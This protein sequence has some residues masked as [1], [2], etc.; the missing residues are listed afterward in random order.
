MR[1]RP[2]TGFGTTAAIAAALTTVTAALTVSPSVAAA[3][4]AHHE[5]P[6]VR[7]AVHGDAAVR[8]LS[9][10][11]GRVAAQN[12]MTSGELRG[13]LESDDSLW[14]APDRSLV[15][16]DDLGL[17]SDRPGQ[18][19]DE[20]EPVPSAR[21]LSTG[22]VLALHS[23][24]GADKVI[25][26]DV[27]GAPNIEQSWT[28]AGVPANLR[29]FDPADDGA[30][31]SDSERDQIE[32][33]WKLV[34]DRFASWNV[35]VTTEDPGPDGLTRTDEADTTY[36][37]QLIVT[38][39]GDPD[40]GAMLSVNG[41]ATGGFGVIGQP[42]RGYVFARSYF[43][44]RDVA[45]VGA[46]EVGHTLGLAHHTSTIHDD[47]YTG[48]ME[49]FGT[50]VNNWSPIMGGIGTPLVQ[51]SRGDF[52]GSNHAQD[53]LA[54]IGQHLALRA[55]EAPSTPGDAVALPAS[56]GYIT[57]SSDVD[58]YVLGTC[59]ADATVDVTPVVE[60]SSLDIDAALVH[61][62]NATPLTTSNE[63]S[64]YHWELAPPLYTT[65]V[66]SFL[67]M[68][69]SLKADAGSDYVL[70][71]RGGGNG[72]WADNG[73]DA[74][75]AV[76]GYTVDVDGCDGAA[77]G[78]SPGATAPGAPTAFAAPRGGE[79]LS[80]TWA[81]PW[82]DGGSAITG[83]RLYRL[84]RQDF[85]PATQAPTG[86]RT[87]VGSLIPA[88]QLSTS[89][90]AP[91][92]GTY[93]YQLVAVNTVGESASA[94]SDPFAYG[95]AVQ[96]GRA[97]AMQ[98]SSNREGQTVSV[99]A[100]VLSPSTAGVTYQ[101]KRSTPGGG[102]EA[103]AGATGNTYALAA[104]DIGR[105]ISV[106]ATATA[107]G[108]RPAQS[109][110]LASV[111]VVS[112]A[113]AGSGDF[114]GPTTGS[115]ANTTVPDNTIGTGPTALAVDDAGN[116]Y[117]PANGRTDGRWGNNYLRKFSAAG[118][119]VETWPTAPP[120]RL[121]V[122]INAVDVGPDGDVYAYD[123]ANR[124][125]LVYDPE[126]ALLRTWP[127]PT[128]G[129]M[130]LQD[131]VYGITVD[132]DGN[133]YVS[134]G[135][136]QAIQKFDA[137]GTRLAKWDS[138]GV[139]IR[140]LQA[141]SG[142]GGTI[143]Y[144]VDTTGQ[145]VKALSAA[146]GAPVGSWNGA[147]SGG[148]QF[149]YPTDVATDESGALYVL[150]GFNGR[151]QRFD[152][153]F[154]F[155]DEVTFS[156]VALGIDVGARG[157]VYVADNSDDEVERV[158][159]TPVDP[160]A[161]PEVT[162]SGQALSSSTPHVGVPVTAVKGTWSPSGAIVTYQW[163]V[164]SNVVSTSATYT[165][166]AADVGKPLTLIFTGTNPGYTTRTVTLTSS[167]V[168]RGTLTRPT[169]IALSGTYAV[170]KKLKVVTTGAWKPA[171]NLAYRWF[172][173]GKAITGATKSKLKLTQAQAGKKILVRITATA[174]G[175]NDVVIALKGKKVG[176]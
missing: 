59:T 90:P 113:S 167:P 67:G 149:S 74:Y 144:Y 137:D 106:T 9:R 112:A 81:K 25:F 2:A 100:P 21:T 103:I 119:L 43:R 155:V 62:G 117:V 143:L 98:A 107:A 92:T 134:D 52:H 96:I 76:G 142:P 172:A 77:L 79:P 13:L 153:A 44:A 48:E 53:D 102:W 171:A 138:L 61:L 170:G 176:T 75:G 111:P 124:R 16:A 82:N 157:Q 88:G 166:V 54:T 11:L 19:A 95:L 27:D 40:I 58:S 10:D 41:L 78:A 91:S 99:V 159:M 136:Q 14:V 114:G 150:E 105:R 7:G 162:S 104:A 163:K 56:V 174:P 8:S 151:V 120:G 68:G 73:F 5:V 94:T 70:Q 28:D 20:S 126:G 65:T 87:Q 12:D 29:G 152:S 109:A 108:L 63:P 169:K 6:V 64:T 51:W 38:S 173:G 135:F 130:I 60:G 139:E 18:P 128:V 1:R 49:E 154:A 30:A 140:G 133:V 127:V 125:V 50:P 168:G 116:L 66:F 22:Q 158:R 55:D 24:P 42:T 23:D 156:G 122:S 37:T 101:W 34:S 93:V 47:N 32:Q 89:F 165:P 145:A 85:S 86:V 147:S 164:G 39:P 132:E 57:S 148:T 3:A 118:D 160:P 35:D 4:A 110:S 71:V 45:D 84:Y 36:G 69:A 26:I 15:W 80:F 72:T 146:T 33:I 46:H 131:E 123:T 161:T 83:Y 115:F 129:M 141:V 97:P 175:Y 31:F 17:E 121:R